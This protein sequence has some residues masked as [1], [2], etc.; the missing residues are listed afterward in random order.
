MSQ[1]DGPDLSTLLGLGATIAAVLLVGLGLGWLLDE[2]LDSLPLFVLIGL[3]LGV[4]GASGYVYA[5][6]KKFMKD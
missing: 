2:V 3:A 5:Q 1:P 4:V 6:F